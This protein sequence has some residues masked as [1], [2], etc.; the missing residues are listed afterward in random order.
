MMMFRQVK[1]RIHRAI[2]R[3]MAKLHLVP[4]PKIVARNIGR[5]EIQQGIGASFKF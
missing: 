1:V 3:T 4:T 2:L 5:S